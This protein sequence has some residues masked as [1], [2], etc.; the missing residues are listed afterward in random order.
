MCT[1]ILCRGR[2]DDCESLK[3]RSVIYILIT[4]RNVR[5][6]KFNLKHRSAKHLLCIKYST[7]YL[8]RTKFK[9]IVAFAVIL[10][11]LYK[12]EMIN[13]LYETDFELFEY[14]FDGDV[15]K[16]VMELRSNIE[17]S[18]QPINEYNYSYITESLQKCQDLTPLRLII[19][20]K[21]ALQHFDQRY[22]IRRTWGYEKRFSDVEIRTVF[23]LGVGNDPKIQAKIE[24]EYLLYQDIIQ[25]N[26]TDT[27]YN[28][29]IKTMIG[30]KW[31]VTK[32]PHAKF[33]LFSD[34]DMYLSIKNLLRYIRHPTKYPDYLSDV[35]SPMNEMLNRLRRQLVELDLPDDV[36]FYSGYVKQATPF[37]NVFS[38]FH[39][40]LEEY[41]Y[42]TYPLYATA[43][44]Y[45]LSREALVDMYYTSLYTKHFRFDD[46]YLGILARK[47]NIMPYHSNYFNLFKVKYIPDNY[48]YLI[49]SHGYQ[50][51]QEL[52]KVW[53]EQK[54]IGN[55]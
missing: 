48:K 41:K 7:L 6:M 20:V 50:D 21:S 2:I 23:L 17:P 5:K 24:R 46:V 36:R 54:E 32:C 22:I 19:L 42:D 34:D 35:K 49:S 38:K 37:R 47:T 55:A 11:F 31:I 43:G 18:K 9:S 40:P 29:T 13:H 44:A 12:S 33:Y 53:T 1:R 14:P 3:Q 4:G 45:I 52:L 51:P 27:Y 26:F 25:V 15:S 16:Y 39:M 8:W 28:N 30:F 10:I